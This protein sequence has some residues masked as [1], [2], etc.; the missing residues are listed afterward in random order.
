MV[1]FLE[2]IDLKKIKDEAYNLDKY[3]NVGTHIGLLYFVK[4]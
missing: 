3:A 2:I 4:K 1:L